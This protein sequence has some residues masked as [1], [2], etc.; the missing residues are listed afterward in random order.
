MFLQENAKET[1]KFLSMNPHMSS[2]TRKKKQKT[3]DISNNYEGVGKYFQQTFH[4]YPYTYKH[5]SLPEPNVPTF[6]SDSYFHS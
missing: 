6:N 5:H 2:P 1:E 4:G 3:Y